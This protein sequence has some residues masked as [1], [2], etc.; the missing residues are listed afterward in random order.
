MQQFTIQRFRGG[1]AVVWYESGKRKRHRLK[2]CTRAEAEAEARDFATGL[3]KPK[4]SLT[5]A[6]LWNAYTREKAGRRVEESMLY[7]GKSIL[8]WFGAL[9]PE[10][11]TIE[12]CRAYVAD[13][14]RAGRKDGTI[15]SQMNSLR[16]CL[17]WAVK[18]GLMTSAPRLELPPK[19]MP[20]ERYLSREEIDSLLGADCAF[21]IRLA[22]ILMLTTGARVSAV[23]DLTWDRV[24]LERRQ[25]NLRTSDSG[26]KGRAIVPI[27]DALL[28]ALTEARVA[29]LS[30][31]VVEWAGKPVKSIK[32]GFG[33]ALKV[34]RLKDVSP[35][36]LRHT[37]AVHMAEAGVN[38]AEISQ[39]L[40]H[41]DVQ[42]TASVYARFS[43]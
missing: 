16:T 24:D 28:A 31:H 1:L 43:P 8:P 15:W 37:A 17:N 14:R 34:A 23:L 41:S 32:T 13:L 9:R 20:K 38:M 6:D 21:H 22:M 2:A 33:K 26:R 11:I 12:D 42:I 7:R 10:Q 4:S 19:G 35:H 30:D 25:I 27:N 3:Q 40:G 39:F 36:V 5:V 29:A 18:S